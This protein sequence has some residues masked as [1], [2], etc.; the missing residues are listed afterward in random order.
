MTTKA[1]KFDPTGKAAGEISLPEAI[2]GTRPKEHLLYDA[3]MMQL[4]SRRQGTA[5]TK[6]R[7]EVRGGGKKPYKQKGTGNARRGT[8]R[9]PLMVGGGRVFGPIPKDWSYRIPREARRQALVSALSQ[10]AAEGK[11][12]VLEGLDLKTPKTKTIA[13]L[14]AKIEARNVLVVD[15]GNETLARS[16]RNIPRTKY[17]DVVGLNV[18][19]VLKYENL[20][21]TTGSIQKIEERL[22]V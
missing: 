8:S 2:F 5:K 1:K 3:V 15:V 13:D 20:L 19:D 4:A 16:V 21:L 18:F 11:L 17:L 10:K 6:T 7:S 12:F 22:S 14:L 9:S